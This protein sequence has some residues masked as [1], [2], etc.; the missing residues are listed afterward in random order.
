MF[1]TKSSRPP[2]PTAVAF[3]A[4]FAISIP[5]SALTFSDNFDSYNVGLGLTSVGPWASSSSVANA[6]ID[7]GGFD[8]IGSI[9]PGAPSYDFYPGNGNYIDLD[10]TSP[11]QGPTFFYVNVSIPPSV[12]TGAWTANLTFDLGQNPGSGGQGKQVTP[13]I[14]GVAQS[15]L[16]TTSTLTHYSETVT[17]NGPLEDDVQVGFFTPSSDQ[18]GPILDNFAF[19]LTPVPE[20][21]TWALM[22]GGLGFLG[23]TARNKRRS[24][25]ASDFTLREGAL[26]A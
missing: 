22:V 26:L 6:G 5:A 24:K 15:T 25:P 9:G 8:V 4:L 1:F 20:P 3:A 2:V 10:G 17:L 16:L 13:Y 7:G 14:N 12:Y 18:Q 19:T 23:W 21:A 11:N